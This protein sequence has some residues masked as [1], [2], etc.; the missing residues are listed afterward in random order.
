MGGTAEFSSHAVM[1]NSMI[2]W[3]FFARISPVRVFRE[4]HHAGVNAGRGMKG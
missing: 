2:V 3:D 1:R 4:R